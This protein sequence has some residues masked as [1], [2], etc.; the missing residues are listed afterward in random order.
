MNKAMVIYFSAEGNTAKVAKELAEQA[1]C[2]VFEIRPENPYTAADINWKNPLA[3]CNKEKIGRK[4]IPIAE[5]P[6]ISAETVFI[7]FPI[8]YAGAPNIIHTF[9]KNIDWSGKKIALFATSGGSNIGRTAD[10]LTPLLGG[11]GEITASKLFRPNTSKED[12]KNWA[13]SVMG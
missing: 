11:K 7:G 2:E 1:D 4:D 8:W 13:A 9:I 5:M 3:R 12:L 6:D 10:K